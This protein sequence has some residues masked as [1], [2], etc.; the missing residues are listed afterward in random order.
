LSV[1]APKEPYRL[2]SENAE[3]LV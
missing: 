1:S 3:S 2:I